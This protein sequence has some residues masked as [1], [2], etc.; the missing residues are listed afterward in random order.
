MTNCWLVELADPI[1]CY[2]RGHGEGSIR[3]LVWGSLN[4]NPSCWVRLYGTGKMLTVRQEDLRT[5][6]DPGD[7]RDG[8]PGWVIPEGWEPKPKEGK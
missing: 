4:A 7:V 6:G 8:T 3:F 5:A 2:V 1:D